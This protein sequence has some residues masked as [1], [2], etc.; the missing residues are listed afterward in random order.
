LVNIKLDT[1]AV[2]ES[3]IQPRNPTYFLGEP[4]PTSKLRFSNS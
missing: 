3:Q 2:M 1:P 4:N